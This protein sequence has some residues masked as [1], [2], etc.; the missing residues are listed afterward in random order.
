M[1]DVLASRK[2][3]KTLA[4]IVAALLLP[5][6][7]LGTLYVRTALKEIRFLDRELVGVEIARLVYGAL[8]SKDHH[9][10]DIDRSKIAKLESRLDIDEEGRFEHHLAAAKAMV[11]APYHSLAAKAP[12]EKSGHA[13]GEPDSDEHAI[14]HLHSSEAALSQYLIEVGDYS[15]LIL[16]SESVS[17]HLANAYM[18]QLPKLLDAHEQLVVRLGSNKMSGSHAAISMSEAQQMLGR[19]SSHI[20]SMRDELVLA[21][22]FADQKLDFSG[23]NKA[24]SQFLEVSASINLS[25]G[26]L[27]FVGGGLSESDKNTL[28]AGLEKTRAVASVVVSEGLGFLGERVKARRDALFRELLAFGTIG[29]ASSLAALTLA[30]FLFRRTLTKLDEIEAMRNVAE[31]SRVEAERV[32]AEVA[33]LNR[34]LSDKI[35]KLAEAQSDIVRKGKMEQLGQL[36]ATVAH[37]LRN[38]LGAVR[39]SAFL[40]GKK[41]E[42]KSLGIDAQLERINSGITRCD[43]IIT[44]LLDYSRTRKITPQLADLD[45]WLATLVSNEAIKLPPSVMVECTLGLGGAH[46]PFDSARLERAVLNL[47]SNAVEAMLPHGVASTPSKSPTLWIST[48][49]TGDFATIRVKDNGPGIAAENLQRIREPLFTTKNFGTGLGIP[50]IEQIAEQHNGRLDIESLIGDGACFDLVIPRQLV[51]RA[52]AAA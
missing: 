51:N 4:F 6:A 39:T 7:I 11:D 30:A 25:L 49:V 13:Q 33:L 2:A 38:P 43:G 45:D 40:I 34:E 9:S 15:G 23:Q 48:A 41:T 47:I 37:E 42:G 5:V 22:R 26:Q 50:A 35:K 19:I 29:L 10:S 3:G 21:A 24:L 17:Y 28:A 8:I 44:Q 20:Q 31:S 36:T 52:D 12:Q 27:T 1:V 32:N 18:V 46:I 16:D 14:D